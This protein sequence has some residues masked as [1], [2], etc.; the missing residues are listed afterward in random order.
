MPELKVFPDNWQ[1]ESVA[2]TAWFVFAQQERNPFAV[3][4]HRGARPAR[5]RSPSAEH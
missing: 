3:F 2:A 4:L 5:S 1:W